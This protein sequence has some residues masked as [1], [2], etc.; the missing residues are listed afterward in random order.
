MDKFQ[1]FVH[2]F[3]RFPRKQFEILCGFVK[4]IY[5]VVKQPQ[6]KV[7]RIAQG[8]SKVIFTHLVRLKF[9]ILRSVFVIPTKLSALI[10]N[11]TNVAGI[12]DHSFSDFSLPPLPFSRSGVFGI[13]AVSSPTLFKLHLH[14]SFTLVAETLRGLFVDVAKSVLPRFPFLK[15]SYFSRALESVI[16]IVTVPPLYNFYVGA[17]ALFIR[18]FHRHYYSTLAMQE[19]YV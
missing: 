1:A 9:F 11:P 18:T 17:S 14:N 3:L 15:V 13:S 19:I 16:A 5:I 2:K 4:P 6:R 8:A 12:P 7:T 10:C